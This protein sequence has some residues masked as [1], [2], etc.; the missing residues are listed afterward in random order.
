MSYYCLWSLLMVLVQGRMCQDA[1]ELAIIAEEGGSPMGPLLRAVNEIARVVAVKYPRV[2]GPSAARPSL[3]PPARPSV[4][5]LCSVQYGN[6]TVIELCCC[7]A[8]IT[9][10]YLTCYANHSS[11]NNTMLSYV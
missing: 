1:E 6:I 10:I 7:H 9:V 5:Q 2:A 3:R 11:T 4:Q 8:A